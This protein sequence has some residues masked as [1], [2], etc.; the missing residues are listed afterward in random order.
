MRAPGEKVLKE[1][2]S[3]RRRGRVGTNV[4][5]RDAPERVRVPERVGVLGVAVGVSVGVSG[6]RP[7]LALV[8]REVRARGLEGDALPLRDDLRGDALAQRHRDG[9]FSDRVGDDAA[10]MTVVPIRMRALHF[11]KLESAPTDHVR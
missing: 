3:P 7:P 1:R 8:P 6:R 10:V 5:R 4:M 2:R 9:R 11:A